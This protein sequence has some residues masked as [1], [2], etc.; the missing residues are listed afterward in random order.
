[1][2]VKNTIAAVKE[3]IA[4][5]MEVRADKKG[6]LIDARVGLNTMKL[7]LQE[8]IINL[9]KA[10][11]DGKSDLLTQQTANFAL[12]LT[13][14]GISFDAMSERK[15]TLFDAEVEYDSYREAQEFA[16]MEEINDYVI[17]LEKTY[18]NQAWTAR[19]NERG[20][21]AEIAANKEL[22]SSLVHLLA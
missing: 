1:M 21:T 11:M 13:E 6:D 15:T 4:A 16:S 2:I 7:G 9:E 5:Y 18:I 20:K 3:E 12:M 14:K 8:A 22:T 19:I 10:R 17:P